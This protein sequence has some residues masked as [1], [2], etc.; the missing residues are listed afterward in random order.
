M[1][2]TVKNEF[3]F[4]T[5]LARRLVVNLS[6]SSDRILAVA[7]IRKFLDENTGNERL[8]T[9]Y[10][11]LL[12]SC[13]QRK[14]LSGIFTKDPH[15]YELIK[16]VP[17]DIDVG[18]PSKA[19]PAAS[20]MEEDANARPGLDHEQTDTERRDIDTKLLR[21][22]CRVCPSC[23]PSSKNGKCATHEELFKPN[24]S[25]GKMYISQFDY[26]PEDA[27]CAHNFVPEKSEVGYRDPEHGTEVEKG[28]RKQES[29]LGYQKSPQSAEIMEEADCSFYVFQEAG[30]MDLFDEAPPE[31]VYPNMDQ[32]TL[33][34][35][36]EPSV[37]PSFE[38]T[39]A[40]PSRS[41]GTC[42]THGS[43]LQHFPRLEQVMNPLSPN[44]EQE[45]FN[46]F[47][48]RREATVQEGSKQPQV[49]LQEGTRRKYHHHHHSTLL[50]SPPMQPVVNLTSPNQEQEFFNPFRGRREVGVREQS[51]QPEVPLEEGTRR[52]YHHSTLLPSVRI[53]PV[54][55]SPSPNQ[56]QE[57]F[58][59]FR[60]KREVTVRERSKQPEV[61]L[62]EGTRRKY[63]HHHHH[64][65]LLPSPRMQPVASL[66][67]PNQEQEFFNPFRG[68]RQ[69]TVREQSKQPEVPLEEGTRRKYH[70]HHSTLLPSPRMQPVA[71]LSSPNEEQEFFNPFR[72][73]METTDQDRI[74]QPQFPLHA[75]TPKKHQH[76]DRRR[77]RAALRPRK[78]FMDESQAGPENVPPPEPCVVCDKE[79]SFRKKKC[80]DKHGSWSP[81]GTDEDDEYF[82][83]AMQTGQE[84]MLG[85]IHIHQY[86][87]MYELP[88]SM[89]P[90][91]REGCRLTQRL[92]DEMMFHEEDDQIADDEIVECSGSP[93][94][95]RAPPQ[96]SRQ[97]QR[98]PDGQALDQFI[99]H[100]AR[101]GPQ[102][103]QAIPRQI[104]ATE[105]RAM[106]RERL[107]ERSQQDPKQE[108]GR[109]PVT[110]S[111]PDSTSN[112][113]TQSLSRIVEHAAISAQKNTT[114]RSV[115]K[116]LSY[117]KTWH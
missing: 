64:S 42:P 57:F 3:L 29:P 7:W 30:E 19:S 91:I 41:R 61:P 103:T 94:S 99:K 59:P 107:K 44:Q 20:A 13:L 76:R 109:C 84:A 55:N 90:Q 28:V 112:S 114:Q 77:I 83:Q 106:A 80:R 17:P 16:S 51:K 86:P 88:E 54:G 6:E 1:D 104:T 11:K 27:V 39:H 116:T 47:R 115:K 34:R 113:G 72:G 36:A 63:H 110:R 74:E 43:T 56:E 32:H 14:R 53:Q 38:V 62:Q 33:P 87:E 92:V 82:T 21:S 18:T 25:K 46:P 79:E 105:E 45:F 58:N 12:L 40:P 48:G 66:P 101:S 71:T 65:T 4:Y 96:T 60:G 81:C 95:S 15:S 49:P 23:R 5:R 31:L 24:S 8:R 93:C 50:S 108:E 78:L 10:L 35:P 75:G 37:H 22:P 89:S 9:I 117:K 69:V 67:S 52:K 68:R 98:T 100:R 26:E 97:G 2:E 102:A 73:R 111:P 70:H 85:D